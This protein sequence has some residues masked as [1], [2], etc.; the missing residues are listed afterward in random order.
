MAK[1]RRKPGST[2]EAVR[3]RALAMGARHAKGVSPQKV[4]TAPWVRLKCQYGCDGYGSSLRCP[5]HS[6]TP[7][8]TR[9][10]LDC[11]SRAILI[12]GDETTDI[13]RIVTDLEREAFL[14][15]FYKA[16]GFACGPCLLCDK[17]AFDKGC[18]HPERARP[19]MEASGI[20]VFRT[21]RAAGLPIDVVTGQD[22][23]QNYYGL[24]LLE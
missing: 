9:K 18:R 10:V 23:E 15:G 8:A 11:Y 22:C 19:A 16:F 6:P 7:E 14:G 17:C 13:T 3:R 4:F 2:V 20:D 12:H 5:P 24:L 1:R 21:A